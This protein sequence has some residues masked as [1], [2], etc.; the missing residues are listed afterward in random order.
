MISITGP[1]TFIRVDDEN[2]NLVA[3]FGGKSLEE[4]QRAAE[5]FCKVRNN[6]QYEGR[7]IISF[8]A[9]FLPILPID[10]AE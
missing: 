9:H 2:G 8:S 6:P 1:R 7:K 10:S 4:A 3:Y 5:E